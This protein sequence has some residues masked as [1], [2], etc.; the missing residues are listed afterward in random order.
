[1][2]KDEKVVSLADSGAMTPVIHPEYR[3]RESHQK[4][5][6][7]V[8]GGRWEDLPEWITTREAAELSGYH[9]DY[10]R[11]LARQ[12]VLPASKKGSMWWVDRD[13]F[14]VFLEEQKASDDARRGPKVEK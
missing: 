9:V 1:M 8:F 11:Q 4:D 2:D 5:G 10:L 3:T 12:G 7:P 13:E 14:L 6:F